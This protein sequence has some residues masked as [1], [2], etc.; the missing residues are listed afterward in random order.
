MGCSRGGKEV[1]GQGEEEVGRC[2]RRAGRVAAGVGVFDRSGR[3]VSATALA[4]EFAANR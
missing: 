1:G 3:K 2:K 4:C